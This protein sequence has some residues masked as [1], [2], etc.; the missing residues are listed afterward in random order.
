VSHVDAVPVSRRP[1]TDPVEQAGSA[2]GRDDAP[3]DPGNPT[4]PSPEVLAA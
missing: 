2:D 3:A 4:I 1:V